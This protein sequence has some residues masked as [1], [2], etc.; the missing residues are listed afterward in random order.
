MG[1]LLLGVNRFIEIH[2]E[3]FF[4]KMEFKVL[5][6]ALRERMGEGMD[7]PNFFRELMAIIT[8]VKEE[9]WGTKKDLGS[10]KIPDSTI[11]NYVKRGFP[12]KIAQRIV[13]N[14]NIDRLEQ[15]IMTSTRLSRQMLV[16]DLSAYDTGL[17]LE[18][19]ASKICDWLEEIIKQAAGLIDKKKIE[20]LRLAERYLRVKEEFGESLFIEAREICPNTGCGTALFLSSSGK[21]EK[22]YEVEIINPESLDSMSN[23]IALCPKCC[24]AFRLMP[25]GK[26]KK[27]LKTVKSLL[28]ARTRNQVLESV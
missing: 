24:A 16:Q 23:T 7:V 18:N 2:R 17:D 28:V 14:L 4:N 27:E 15:R 8:D 10:K 21:I 26:R 11:K 5:F 22:V 3:S 20:S 13:S 19:V 12:K 9:D 1:C 6:T 25:A